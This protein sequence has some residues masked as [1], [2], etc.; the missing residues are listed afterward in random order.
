MRL[1]RPKQ[2][3]RWQYSLPKPAKEFRPRLFASRGPAFRVNMVKVS[4]LEHVAGMR[5]RDRSQVLV[6]PERL[7]SSP[8]LGG[9]L[10][11]QTV[12]VDERPHLPFQICPAVHAEVLPWSCVIADQLRRAGVRT[13]MV[14]HSRLTFA[15]P[16]RRFRSRRSGAT[17]R[18]W[19]AYPSRVLRRLDFRLRGRGSVRLSESLSLDWTHGGYSCSPQEPGENNG[20]PG[21]EEWLSTGIAFSWDASDLR[22]PSIIP[23]W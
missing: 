7:R 15:P 21:S 3:R 5:S 10:G 16:R 6:P 17:H 11:I 22:A 19:R 1:P 4:L 9:D 13:E 2:F 12:L 8:R 20:R 23:T 14:P 18:I